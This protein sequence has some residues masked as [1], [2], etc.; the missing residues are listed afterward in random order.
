M[1]PINQNGPSFSRI[2]EILLLVKQICPRRTQIDDFGTPIPILLQPRT[3]EAV[4]GVAYALTTTHNAFVLIIAEGALIADTREGC[5]P[6]VRIAG[7]TFAV[8]FFAQARDVDAC[9]FAAHNK[10]GMVARHVWGGLV[11]GGVLLF[12]RTAVVQRLDY[13]S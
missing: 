2:P 11:G 9:L 1:T 7:R 4:K 6:N 8:A 10:V 3:L 13:C 12:A 5:G